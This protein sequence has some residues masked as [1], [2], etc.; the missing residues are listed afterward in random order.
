MP[1]AG[2]ESRVIE[3][4]QPVSHANDVHLPA[5]VTWHDAKAYAQWFG[6]MNV[7]PVRMAT[8]EYLHADE[9]APQRSLPQGII[10]DLFGSGADGHLRIIW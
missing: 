4:W 1:T 2:A 6:K 9:H 3:P 8:E 5:A 10:G 7:L